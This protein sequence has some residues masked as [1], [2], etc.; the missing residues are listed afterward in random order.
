MS[1]LHVFLVTHTKTTRNAIKKPTKTA[2]SSTVPTLQNMID[3]TFN[4]ELAR[5]I[6]SGKQLEIGD[7]ILTRMSGYPPW[8]ADVEGLTKDK[9]RIKCYFYGSHNRGSVDY[10]KTLPF[11]D[12]L[13]T[14]RLLCLRQPKDFVKGVREIEIKYGVPEQFS[15]LREFETIE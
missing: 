4:N 3:K 11:F 9:K 10:N 13:E 1:I 7:P 2:A 14:I 8:P 12:A 5:F 15:C 6:E